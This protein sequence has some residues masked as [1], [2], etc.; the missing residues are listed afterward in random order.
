MKNGHETIREL[1]AL[2]A[3]GALDDQE[4]RRVEE[5]ATACAECAAELERWQSLAG[6]LRRVPTPQPSREL[7][8]RVRAQAEWKLAQEAERRRDTRVMALLLMFS[9]TILLTTWPLVRLMGGGVW[10]W[11]DAMPGHVW[12]WLAGYTLLGWL[13]AGAAVLLGLRE[14]GARRTA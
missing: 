3:A 14:R 8:A 2:A 5:H 1:L 7:I 11:L 4:A 9:W 6:A 12:F 13:A 10:A